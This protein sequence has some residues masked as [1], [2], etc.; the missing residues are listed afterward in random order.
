MARFWDAVT[1]LLDGKRKEATGDEWH[2]GQVFPDRVDP[3]AVAASLLPS[4]RR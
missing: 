1:G 3:G 2:A 4:C